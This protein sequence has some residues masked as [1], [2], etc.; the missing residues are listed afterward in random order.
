MRTFMKNTMSLASKTISI[1]ACVL[2]L[3]MNQPSLAQFME[4]E[5]AK[6]SSDGTAMMLSTAEDWST[7]LVETKIYRWSASTGVVLIKTFPANTYSTIYYGNANGTT[8]IGTHGLDTVSKVWRWTSTGGFNDAIG[9]VGYAQS[10]LALGITSSDAT[11]IAGYSYNYND[12]DYSLRSRAFRWV[13][14]SG[15]TGTTTDIGVAPGDTDADMYGGVISSD[16]TVIFARSWNFTTKAAHLFR[17]QKTSGTSG[18]ILK[19]ADLGD[20]DDTSPEVNYINAN[21]TTCVASTGNA[22]VRW[23]S[24]GLNSPNIGLAGFTGGHGVGGVSSDGTVIAGHS[25]NGYEYDSSRS[26]AFRWVAGTGTT[27]TATPLGFLPGDTDSDTYG[28]DNKSISSD[29]TVIVGRSWKVDS[30]GNQVGA[31]HFFRWVKNAS[32]NSGVM[33][34]IIDIPVDGDCDV[35]YMNA[36]GTIIVGSTSSYG[37]EGT[38]KVWRWTSAGGLNS[39]IGLS[40]Y[41]NHSLSSVSS[42]G[43]VIAGMSSSDIQSTPYKVNAFRW[44]ATTATG[45]A[46]TTTAL[47]H[48]AGDTDEDLDEYGSSMSLDGSVIVGR[49]WNS[50]SPT[51]MHAFRWQKT[52]G[53]SGVMTGIVAAP[54]ITTVSP[55]SGPLTAG[56]AFTITG[57]NLTGAT[58]VTVGGVAATSV[59]V[60]SATSITAKTPVGTA[61]AK[62][63]AVTTAGGTATKASGFTY[64]TAPTITTVS[65]T[66]GP[67][68]AG[69]AFTITGTNLTGATSVKVNGVA[70]TNVVVVSAT[71]ITAKTPAGTAGAKSV[72]VTTVGGTATKASAFTYV[73]APTITTVS[74]ASGPLAAGTAFT[75]TGTN[76]TGATSVKVNGVAAT[77]VVVVS[78]TS[79]TA[80]TPTGTAGAKSVAVTTVGGTATKAS[81]FTYVAAPTITTV[82][83]AS[84]PLAAGTAFTITGTNLTGAT[85]V[86]VNGVAATSV[87]VVSATSITARTPAGTVE[88][89]RASCRER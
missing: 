22:I 67:L 30:Q 82:S 62:S 57:T 26:N 71:S 78:A 27:G 87:V 6:V 5:S 76:L 28:T 73:A 8:A 39:T 24:A 59:V 58:N 41:S 54:T 34:K 79:I 15:S 12:Q 64:V 16:G 66:S 11:V 70:A 72:A 53:N 45:S 56:T 75:I 47:G 42:D 4:F 1:A 81:A 35:A 18:T 63:V 14:G 83:P 37:A 13:A 48:L 89:G 29:G 21:G 52:T 60:V 9:L 33:T 32:N 69:T 3:C 40:T 65:P 50:S 44:V 55:T 43:T 17:W 38:N 46:G 88:I 10:E 74:P 51:V 80:K 31:R 36:N 7:N 84:G 49:S 2:S 61:G 77:S 86:K 23:T 19:I 25:F 20:V 68:A 85:S